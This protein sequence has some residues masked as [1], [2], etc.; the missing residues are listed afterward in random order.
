MNR[1]REA[2]LNMYDA[3]IAGCDQDPLIPAIVPAFATA[4]TAFKAKVAEIHATALVLDQNITGSAVDKGEAKDNAAH[5]HADAAD[6]IKAYAASVSN[7]TLK[8][9]VNYSFRSLMRAAD[10]DFQTYCGI[11][12]QA[13]VDNAAALIPFGITAG[14]VTAL[15]TSLTAW[16]TALP[17]PVNK[18]STRKAANT[19]IEEQFNEADELLKDQLDNAIAP[20]RTT[21]PDFYNAYFNNRKIIDNPTSH[22]QVAGLITNSVT[23]E[24]LFEVEVKATKDNV[25][26]YT[27]LSLVNGSYSLK[28]PIPGVYTITFTKAGFETKQVINVLVVLGQ[29]TTIE[30][31]LIAL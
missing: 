23:N 17:G 18:R 7:N 26:F 25:K 20:Y 12:I 30:V 9:L 19:A 8:E 31:A 11:I 1:K 4:F 24:A 2:K 21:H 22:T 16:Q 15:N 14:T 29:T 27:V 13:A 3:V 6:S 5:L 28:I 10:E